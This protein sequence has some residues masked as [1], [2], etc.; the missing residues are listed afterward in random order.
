ML[1]RIYRLPA[2]TRLNLARTYSDPLFVLKIAP[3]SLSYSRFGFIISKKVTPLAV[4][5][6]R[7]KRLLRSCV[8]DHFSEIKPAHDHLFIIRKNL[9]DMKKEDVYKEIKKAF[10]L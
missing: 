2:S 3:N 4:D 9:S 8:E 5:R 10:N 1:K 7:S 6:N